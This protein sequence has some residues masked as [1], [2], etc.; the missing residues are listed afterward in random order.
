V[1]RESTTRRLAEQDLKQAAL[2]IDVLSNFYS[3]NEISGDP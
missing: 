3:E 2:K 1:E